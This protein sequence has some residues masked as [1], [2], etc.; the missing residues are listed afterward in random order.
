VDNE[1]Y[2]TIYCPYCKTNFKEKFENI[3]DENHKAKCPNCGRELVWTEY[4]DKYLRKIEDELLKDIL[5]KSVPNFGK[6]EF[7]R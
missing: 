2:T 7:I 5:K 6:K 1:G 4:L 3:E